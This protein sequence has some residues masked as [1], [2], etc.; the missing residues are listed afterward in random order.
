MSYFRLCLAT[1]LILLPTLVHAGE[2]R[3]WTDRQGRQIEA[4]F[5][6]VFN[7]TAILKQGTR[8]L[9][10]PL[11]NLSEADQAFVNNDG[12]APPEEVAQPTPLDAPTAPEK[13]TWTDLNG[14]QIE[15]T[16]VRL[17]ASQ[18]VL[19]A[20]GRVKSLDIEKFTDDD[21]AYVKQLL[22]AQGDQGQADA[23]DQYLANQQ[24][25]S[26]NNVPSRPAG[27]R[28]A[29]PATPSF[30]APDSFMQQQLAESRR[31]MEEQQQRMEQ[32]REQ[33][34]QRREQAMQRHQEQM[35][36]QQRDSE[37]RR[38]QQEQE[39][40][41][42]DAEMQRQR[43]EMLANNS[44]PQNNRVDIPSPSV[45]SPSVPS[46]PSYS[47]NSGPAYEVVYECGSCK[48]E[49]PASYGAGSNCPHCGIVFNYVED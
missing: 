49:V 43:E 38:Q 22:V 1:A 37:S 36:Q 15:A 33:D 30:T 11:N 5:V 19:E 25:A 41:E 46:S 18:V 29:T 27:V 13:R 3:S 2:S 32:Q 21:H 8:I 4:E 44:R 47:H 20:G 10:V 28:P 31:R 23:L 9:S 40:R 24:Q 42:R 14:N 12:E 39:R 35:A 6:R 34:R 17:H 7:G 48:K 16:F 26:N 45:P